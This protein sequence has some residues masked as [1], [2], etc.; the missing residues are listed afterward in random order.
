MK[1]KKNPRKKRTLHIVLFL[2][3]FFIVEKT[4][5]VLLEPYTMQAE[6]DRQL[7]YWDAQG[8][9]PDMVA[10]GDSTVGCG[11]EPH[12][13]AGEADG[14]HFVL[15]AASANQPI[16]GSYYYL[17]YL[18]KK[19]P[20]IRYVVMGLTYDQLIDS[21]TN[22]QKKLLL[23]DRIH[24]PVIWISYSR[25]VL[26]VEDLPLLL[27]SYRYRARIKDIPATVSDKAAKYSDFTPTEDVGYTPNETR[28]DPEKG[29]VGIGDLHWKEDEVDQNSKEALQN[30]I[31]FCAEEGISLTLVTM[32]VGDALFYHNEGIDPAHRYIEEIAARNG[33]IYLDFNLWKQRE[34]ENVDEQMSDNV[35]IMHALSTKL[36]AVLGQVIN[37]E[38]SDRF[39]YHSV[40][41]AREQIHGI[42]HV[43]LSTT[44]NEDGSRQMSATWIGTDHLKPEFR[45]LV[46]DENGKILLD[47]GR[48]NESTAVL[49][50]ELV[51]QKMVCSVT[52]YASDRNQNYQRTYSISV[53]EHTWNQE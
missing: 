48:Q 38:A 25:R 27:K 24:D 19:Y 40:E 15:N 16:E 18:K 2:I 33:I 26:S 46:T 31:D 23:L 32:P 10:L 30:I 39:L 53:D 43:E 1:F 7:S 17:R 47:S 52:A 29:E 51:G 21:Q 42:L 22:M 45:F 37:G 6:V 13:L 3:L 41:E 20:G 36:T 28:L 9:A 4:L 14:I 8:V 49:P 5:T 11:I 50:A 34:E 35:H 12:T 44:L